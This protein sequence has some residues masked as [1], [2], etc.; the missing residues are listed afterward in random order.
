MAHDTAARPEGRRCRWKP[1][2]GA[3]ESRTWEPTYL[4]KRPS[5]AGRFRWE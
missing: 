5:G 1:D 4:A 3:D 2:V